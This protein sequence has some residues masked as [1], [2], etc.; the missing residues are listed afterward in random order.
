M[1]VCVLP[2][3][4]CFG[5]RAVR[6]ELADV[7]L[8]RRGV[9][10]VVCSVRVLLGLCVVVVVVGAGVVVVTDCRVT[11]TPFRARPSSSGTSSTPVGPQSMKPE[12]VVVCSP[13]SSSSC[14]CRRGRP[15]A[16]RPPSKNASE[17]RGDGSAPPAPHLRPG[18]TA[19]RRR[20]NRSSGPP[21]WAPLSP[22]GER[23]AGCEEE[24]GGLRRRFPRVLQ[25]GPPTPCR[26]QIGGARARPPGPGAGPSLREDPWPS[27]EQ[28]DR[29]TTR[30]STVSSSHAWRHM[31]N[32]PHCTHTELQREHTHTH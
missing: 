10:V 18:C 25:Y 8:S 7:V 26:A 27:G 20:A 2:G 22:A 30:C 16:L 14:S 3:V 9:C 31:E 24:G 15:P 13:G 19:R 5:G 29:S 1:C 11:V 32:S 23:T 17:S 12:T 28:M 6:T 4:S 21:P